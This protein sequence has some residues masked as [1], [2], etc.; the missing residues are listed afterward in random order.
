MEVPESFGHLRHLEMAIVCFMP[1]H[2]ECGAFMIDY[3]LWERHY[4]ILWPR[5]NTDM[6]FLGIKEENFNLKKIDW[7]IEIKL[8]WSVIIIFRRWKWRQMGLNAAAGLSYTETEWS[9]EWQSI[10]D[11]AS[12]TIRNQTATSYQSLEEVPQYLFSLTTNFYF[13]NYRVRFHFR[14]TF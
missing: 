14:Y 11:M 9:S 13:G 12:P 3:L 1:H 6:L 10:V 2:W 5:E 8:Y 4:I 7:T